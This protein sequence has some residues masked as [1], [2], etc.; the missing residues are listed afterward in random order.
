M[1]LAFVATIVF[2][3]NPGDVFLLPLMGITIGILLGM[4]IVLLT[5]GDKEYGY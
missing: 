5:S 2:T 1:K 4:L 3:A